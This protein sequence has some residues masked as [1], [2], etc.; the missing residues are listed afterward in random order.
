MSQK[1]LDAAAAVCNEKGVNS[2]ALLKAIES[3]LAMALRKHLGGNCNVRVAM[4]PKKGEYCAFQRWLVIDDSQA[5]D[6]S[7]MVGEEEI[8]IGAETTILFSAAQQEDENI[9]VGDYVEKSIPGVP[10]GRIAAQVAK[11]VITQELR[12]AERQA[13]VEQF[14]ERKGDLINSTVKKTTRDMLILDLGNHVE[15]ALKR[16]DMI[17]RE[18]FR[19]GD[20]VRAILVDSDTEGRGPAIIFSRIVPEFLEAIFSLEVPEIAEELI[21]IKGAVRD[22]GSRAKI[23]VKTN[24][25]RIDPKGACVGMRGARVQ[26]VTAE[27]GGERVDIVEWDGNPVQFVIN[28]MAPAEVLSI[29]VDEESASMDVAVAESQL[30]QAI[31][32]G[33][34]NVRLASEL[35]G[36]KLNV[37]TEQDAQQKTQQ[38]EGAVVALLAEQ[39]D[40]D[41]EVAQVLQQAGFSSLDE[42]AY[43][44]I[45]DFIEAVEEL[46]EEAITELQERAKDSLLRQALTKKKEISSDDSIEELDGVD[47]D[48]AALLIKHE[49]NKVEDLAECAVFDLTE[50]GIPEE[51]AGALIMEARKPWFADEQDK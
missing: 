37:M 16:T 47:S 31:G 30:S 1:I 46:D 28:A 4:D 17:P 11:Q 29:V 44:E 43:V 34:Q 8:L 20:R 50:W 19:P 7:I 27:L 9:S 41:T 42:I 24:D 12:K 18:V 22:P 38:E 23:A 14:A 48:I 10:L 13:I 33:G 35:T 36:W 26:A 21:E 6:E 2:T 15:G 39:L 5:E 25:G 49:I 3:G 32:R 40:I 45:A 51:K